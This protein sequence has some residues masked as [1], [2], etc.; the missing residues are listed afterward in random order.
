MVRFVEL[1]LAAQTAYAELAEQARALE[2]SNALAGLRGSFQRMNRKKTS[3]WYFAYR[4]L[5]QRVRMAYVGPD[6]PRVRDLVERFA[7]VRRVKP[8]AASAQSA[9]ALGCTRTA[10]K[11]FRV[12]K[13]LAEYGFFR[14]G[15]VLIGIHA[16]IALGNLLGVRWTDGSTTLDVD[17]AHAGRNVSIALPATVRIDVHGALESLE[18]GLLPITQFDGRVGA[19]YRNPEDEELRIDFVTSMVRRSGPVVMPNLNLAL[20]PLKFMEF[21]LEDTT[22]ACLIARTGACV[23][24]VPAPER[25]AV[26][27]LI[28][29]GERPMRERTKA[30]KDLLQ[31]GSLA[32]YFLASAQAAAFNA[33]WREALARG[34]GWR[35]RAER[36]RAALIAI[37]PELDV[38]ELWSG[39]GV[40]TPTRRRTGTT[41]GSDPKTTP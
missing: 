38:T 25:F 7:A 16:F 4:D 3:Y 35:L 29:H 5:D 15:G 41:V 2:L 21:I 22:Q 26:H 17:F 37:A 31:V 18:M 6:E 10:P 11:H 20:E 39:R 8:L 12:I 36:G 28:V 33:V 40:R 23:V 30:R 13:R 34:R 1:P 9:L 14:A 27:K 32:A 19:Q 24:N